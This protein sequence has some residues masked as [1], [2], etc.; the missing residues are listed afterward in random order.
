[1]TWVL[2]RS[3]FSSNCE[4]RPC[5]EPSRSPFRYVIVYETTVA[6]ALPQRGAETFQTVDVLLDP[7]SFSEAT[8]KR[9]FELLS[10]RFSK[11]NRL[12]VHVHT[13]LDDLYTPEENDQGISGRCNTLRGD[14]HAWALYN[15]SD[16]Y[17]GFDYK[18]TEPG[19]SVIT[20]RLRGGPN[21]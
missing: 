13:H 21:R 5:E 18:L 1:P 15:R 8:L 2:G 4:Q 17:E 20:V 7:S 11:S 14:K 12:F 9:L 19:G 10:K 3:H 6:S 16:A